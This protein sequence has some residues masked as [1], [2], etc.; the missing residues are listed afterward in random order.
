[1]REVR[2]PIWLFV[3]FGATLALLVTALLRLWP[4]G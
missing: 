2:K 1:M 4:S 3:A